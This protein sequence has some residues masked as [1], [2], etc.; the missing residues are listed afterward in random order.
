MSSGPPLPC[1]DWLLESSSDPGWAQ[2]R[3]ALSRPPGLPM[4]VTFELS[5]TNTLG[6]GGQPAV[7]RTVSSPGECPPQGGAPYRQSLLRG[8]GLPCLTVKHRDLGR[9]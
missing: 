3:W 9:S 5:T 1:F 7:T 4:P 2:P 6:E 8:E